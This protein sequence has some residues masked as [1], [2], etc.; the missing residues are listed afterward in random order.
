VS[1]YISHITWQQLTLRMQSNMQHSRQRVNNFCQQQQQQPV[2]MYVSH[3]AQQQN[4][5]A[6]QYAD[7]KTGTM[8]MGWS[9]D[10]KKAEDGQWEAEAGTSTDEQLQH[11]TSSC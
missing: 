1:I 4:Y 8:W 7:D 5:T 9:R 2:R 10:A 6:A 11:S 3:V